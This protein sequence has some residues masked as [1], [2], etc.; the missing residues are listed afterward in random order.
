[1][2]YAKPHMS[3]RLGNARRSARTGRC[4]ARKATCHAW[5]LVLREAS[6]RPDRRFWPDDWAELREEPRPKGPL[7]AG[8]AR[9]GFVTC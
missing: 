2:E 1:M 8:R 6:R 5:E 4:R 9:P 3:M 7:V